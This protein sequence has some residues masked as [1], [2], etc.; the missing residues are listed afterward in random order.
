MLAEWIVVLIAVVLVYYL[1]R[2]I[3]LADAGIW[4]LFNI[5]DRGRASYGCYSMEEKVEISDSL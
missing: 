4:R 2:I 5:A 1:P 3:N